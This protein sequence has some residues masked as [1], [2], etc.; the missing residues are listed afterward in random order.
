MTFKEFMM[1]GESPP[2]QMN[3]DE[4]PQEFH[5]RLKTYL[6]NGQLGQGDL[7]DIRKMVASGYRFD[8]ALTRALEQSL[9]RKY[10]RMKTPNAAP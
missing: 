2:P 1:T 5:S 3:R 10:L 6:A 9:T 4:I 8:D 7:M